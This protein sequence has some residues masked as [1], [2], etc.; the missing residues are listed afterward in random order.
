MGWWPGGAWGIGEI[1]RL[2]FRLVT[3]RATGCR[4]LVLA[5]VRPRRI[6]RYP[7]AHLDFTPDDDWEEARNE[8]RRRGMHWDA[9]E[10]QF[11]FDDP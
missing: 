7:D 9:R 2:R 3:I 1:R 5:M 10:E 11:V 4:S 8:V 6:L